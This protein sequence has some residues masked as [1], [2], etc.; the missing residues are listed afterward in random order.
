[1]GPVELAEGLPVPGVRFGVAGR[2]VGHCESVV[3][4]V[5]LEGVV[6]PGVSERAF[7]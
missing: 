7:Q 6:D 3:G 1:M 4:G 5:E 2:V